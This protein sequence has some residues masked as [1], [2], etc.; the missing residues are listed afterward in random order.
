[1]ID[2]YRP[3]FGANGTLIFQDW[4]DRGWNATSTVFTGNPSFGMVSNVICRNNG[5]GWDLGDGNGCEYW[6][7]SNLRSFSNMH[8]GYCRSPNSVFVN[9]G[10]THNVINGLHHFNGFNDG[11]SSYTNFNFNHNGTNNLYLLGINNGL[12]FNGC[13]IFD[14]GEGTN[15]GKIRIEGCKGIAINGGEINADIEIIGACAANTISNAYFTNDTREYSIAGTG[16]AGLFLMNCSNPRGSGAFPFNDNTFSYT[17]GYVGA[18]QTGQ[19][20]VATPTTIKV[21]P[22]TAK[23]VG[24]QSYDEPTGRWVARSA[25]RHT[26]NAYVDLGGTGAIAGNYVLIKINGTPYM[27][28]PC[29]TL[30][31]SDVF[32]NVVAE[33]E[34][35]SVGDYVEVQAFIAAGTIAPRI[36]TRISMR[37]M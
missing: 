30:S 24:T 25:G 37:L 10:C 6:S 31:P 32:C 18:G 33:F 36:R 4:S 19:I 8:G 17:V 12:S 27:Y 13:Q 23:T 2:C 7:L 29:F 21:T 9:G 34:N 5:V 11:H 20:P 35:L 15:T 16:R 28:A 26:L 22:V 1:M 3:T 14:D